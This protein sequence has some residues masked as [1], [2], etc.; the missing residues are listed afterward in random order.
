MVI[1]A[2][3]W[4]RLEFQAKRYMPWILLA[5]QGS[6]RDASDALFLDYANASLP[7]ALRTSMRKKHF[8]VLGPL[9]I[10]LVLL[11]EV[12]LSTGVF[13]RLDVGVEREMPA[14]VRD[15]FVVDGD[16]GG[17]EEVPGRDPYAVMLGIARGGM[18][19]PEGYTPGL[20]Y[21]TFDLPETAGDS[22]F[23]MG[24]ETL[25]VRPECEVGKIEEDTAGTQAS[26]TVGSSACGGGI[27]VSL[28]SG[29]ADEEQ[30]H[31]VYKDLEGEEGCSGDEP[32]VLAGVFQVRSASDGGLTHTDSA[33]VVCK[34]PF[35]SGRR[36]VTLR[37]DAEPA[38]TP[39][40]GDDKL[41]EQS[42]LDPI[43]DSLGSNGT[44]T[45][46][47]TG[48]DY[49][50]DEL[51]PPFVLAAHLARSG[52][53]PA[54]DFLDG[55]SL[56]NMME[57][58]LDNFGPLAAHYT[59]REDNPKLSSGTATTTEQRLRVASGIAHSMTALFMLSLLMAIPLILH[60]P[61]RGVT[62]QCP[63]SV[64]GTAVLLVNSEDI[65]ERLRGADTGSL[66]A[67]EE[68][69]RGSY[70][71]AVE[72]MGPVMRKFVLKRMP[73]GTPDAP[74]NSPARKPQGYNPWVLRALPRII[75]IVLAAALA[76]ALWGLIAASNNN[77]GLA[78]VHDAYTRS[79]LWTCL[80]AA[81]VVGLG[82]YLKSADFQTRFLAPFSALY[83]ADGFAAGM[84]TTYTDEL[85]PVTVYKAVREKS[86]AVVLAKGA[87]VMASVMPIL[88]CRLYTPEDVLR[89]TEMEVTQVEWFE[90]RSDGPPLVDL[91]ANNASYPWVHD[92][93]VVPRVEVEGST[94]DATIE[95]R[96][97]AV[98]AEL[99]CKPIKPSDDDISTVECELLDGERTVMCD[100][101][102]ANDFFAHAATRCISKSTG[103]EFE[104]FMHYLWGSCDGG[105]QMGRRV[106]S[107]EE[108]VVEVEARAT[109]RGEPLGV[110]SAEEYAG[111]RR[112]TD[113]D[114]P[115][116][117]VYDGLRGEADPWFD[118]FFTLLSHTT[119]LK[120]STPVSTLTSAI[121]KQHA[122]LRGQ[123]LTASRTP[124]TAHHKGTRT[125]K[126]TRLVQHGAPTHLLA[127]ALTLAFGASAAAAVTAPARALP[128]SPGCVG[129]VAGMLAE[130]GMRVV[131]VGAE[132][133]GD[134]TLRRYFEGG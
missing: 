129:A 10:S 110:V 54:D 93:L 14:M 95:A 59:L 124:T 106:V 24:V 48:E 79:V 120:P 40:T 75:S 88:V 57:G 61:R 2:A 51:P 18:A 81:A 77:Q 96:L 116:E 97:P 71:S 122:T 114:L 1:V 4:G 119:P 63:N 70:Y 68:R 87:A 117:K 37:P 65:F 94:R 53:P 30:Y 127:V 5:G 29:S 28:A 11:V 62:P 41:L 52:P 101:G 103:E 50:T 128:C 23:Q 43:H 58:F 67:I 130:W 56:G 35:Y 73:D 33:A 12:V 17:L 39:A 8:L 113:I 91:A 49:M 16:V 31:F 109:M 98:R 80:P 42:L 123:A 27:P 133:M 100:A 6:P 15:R 132:W 45:P 84:T 20:A 9:I 66:A 85:A 13:I 121:E 76:A 3:L 38:I 26:F 47:V 19:Y 55:M 105:E 90:E 118:A 32:L 74:P 108:R 131:P 125:E 126:T 83:S 86:W 25:S 7:T 104:A 46:V 36:D 111:S 89:E 107:C 78:P 60:V 115:R 44:F 102:Q 72:L 112:E 134:A 99:T 92:N 82:A 69:L 34:V 64:A 21:Q 22:S